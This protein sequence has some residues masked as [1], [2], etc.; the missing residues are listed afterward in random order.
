MKKQEL[1]S[2][3]HLKI[4]EEKESF[5]HIHLEE[6]YKLTPWKDGDDILE[7]YASECFYFPIKDEYDD[8]RVITEEED[9]ELMDLRM[10][11][12]EEERDSNKQL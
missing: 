12:E 5:V 6:G 7:Y 8:F 4:S 3:E 9:R 11:K 1:M 2:L 10:K